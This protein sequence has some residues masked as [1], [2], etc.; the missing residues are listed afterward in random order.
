VN[1][2]RSTRISSAPPRFNASERLSISPNTNLATAAR[3]EQPRSQTPLSPLSFWTPAG[4]NFQE[5]YTQLVEERLEYSELYTNPS[6]M[7][8]TSHA[9]HGLSRQSRTDGSTISRSE[10]SNRMP[11]SRDTE[12]QLSRGI[13]TLGIRTGQSTRRQT[14][15]AS[16][17]LTQA[18]PAARTSSPTPQE[19]ARPARNPARRRQASRREAITRRHVEGE[20]NICI[21]PLQDEG[22]EEDE[23]ETENGYESE[24]SDDFSE[25]DEEESEDSHDVQNGYEELVWCKRRC[26]NNFHRDCIDSWIDACQANDREPTCPICRAEWVLEQ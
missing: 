24:G 3:M 2:P 22:S 25:Q 6:R 14:N 23:P 15:A 9:S 17:R 4:T 18:R 21:L 12:S 1:N 13:S 16:S 19:S 7:A 5:Y 10:S 11:S 26:G 20:C 8:G